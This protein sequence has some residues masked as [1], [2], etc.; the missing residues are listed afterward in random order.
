MKNIHL[1][2]LRPIWDS[3]GHH[4]ALRWIRSFWQSLIHLAIS[5]TSV[6]RARRII[7]IC[8]YP[9]CL[10]VERK[11]NRTMFYDESLHLNLISLWVFSNLLNRTLTG[12]KNVWFDHY[13]FRFNMCL[14]CRNLFF[15]MS[16]HTLWVITTYKSNERLSMSIN[17]IECWCMRYIGKWMRSITTYHWITPIFGFCV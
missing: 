7:W 17:V 5:L 3:R 12:D 1:L 15:F 6:L 4:H 16:K 9:V 11:L 2:C 14:S 13:H 10:G 8:Q